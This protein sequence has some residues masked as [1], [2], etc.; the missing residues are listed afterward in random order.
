M[1]TN[2]SL[3]ANYLLKSTLFYPDFVIQIASASDNTL[4]IMPIK[5]ALN[6]KL[7]YDFLYKDP[8]FCN[9]QKCRYAFLIKFLICMIH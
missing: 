2:S 8:F 4:Y 1:F 9:S 3:S 6:Y 5:E 7:I